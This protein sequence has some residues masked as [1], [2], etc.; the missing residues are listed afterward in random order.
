MSAQPG[1]AAGGTTSS[2]GA[3]IRLVVA[4]SPTCGCCALWIDHLTARSVRVEVSHP[5]SLDAVFAEHQ[6]PTDL[7]ACHLATTPDGAV[8]VGHIP[9][10]FL[11]DYLREPPARARGLAVPGMPVGTPGMESGDAFE[12][13]QVI[14]LGADGSTSVY[15]DVATAADQRLDA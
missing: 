13:Y 6:I 4:K 5:A 7:R 11:V 12:P 14:Q 10:P 9:A 15:A 1:S 3:G 8:F 2:A